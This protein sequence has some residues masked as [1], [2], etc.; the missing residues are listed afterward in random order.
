MLINNAGMA[1]GHENFG[2]FNE[3]TMA[4]VLHVNAIA[5]FLVTQALTPL[6]QRGNQP[7]VVYITSE[8][9]SIEGASGLSFGLSYG[10]SKAALNMGGKK[11]ASTLKQHGIASVLLHPGWVQTDMGGKSAPVQPGESI[12]GM[13]QVIDRLTVKDDLRYLTFRGEELPW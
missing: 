6:L 9:G 11:L 13:L 2:Q 8:L 3:E 7:K 1:A 10:M 12:R 5:P 4:R